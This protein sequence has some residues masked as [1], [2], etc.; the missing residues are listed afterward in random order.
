M[1]WFN[2]SRQQPVKKLSPLPQVK[3]KKG[4]CKIKFKSKDNVDDIEFSSECTTQ[5]IEMAKQMR[6]EGHRGTNGNEQ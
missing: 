3:P 2:R 6:A 4:K 5:Q 1:A